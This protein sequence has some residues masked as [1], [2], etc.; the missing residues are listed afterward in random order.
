RPL[1]RSVIGSAVDGRVVEFPINVGDRVEAG[2]TLAQLLTETIKLEV[3]AAEAELEL[4]QEELEELENGS[5]PEEIEQA[6]AR[7]EAASANK[8]YLEQRRTRIEKLR[9]SNAASEDVVQETVSQSLAADEAYLEA[10]AAWDL[11]VRGP[12]TEK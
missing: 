5:L 3:A 9:Q 10:K 11:A 12:R 4:R 8:E 7:K 2:Q 6:R 1:K